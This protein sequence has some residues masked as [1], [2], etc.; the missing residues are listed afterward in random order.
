MH[1]RWEGTYRCSQ[2]ET[3][4]MLTLD[5]NKDGSLEAVFEF[6]PTPENPT[7]PTGSYKLRGIVR[8]GKEGS[9]DIALDP[10]EWLDQPDGYIMVSM[11]ATSSRKW[12]RLVGRI[13]H[14]SCGEI[15]VRRADER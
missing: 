13:D 8:A 2:G 6:G 5:A 4:V 3:A 11:S 9:F 10:F 1:S 12:Q 7:V 14:P 15:T